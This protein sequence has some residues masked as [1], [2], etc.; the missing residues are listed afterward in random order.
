MHIALFHL[1]VS[2]THN[3]RCIL[4]SRDQVRGTTRRIPH[5]PGNTDS[6][7]RTNI[8]KHHAYNAVEASEDFIDDHGSTHLRIFCRPLH[9]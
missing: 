8:V 5:E 3:M 7:L 1:I 9:R 4:S 6:K 2:D